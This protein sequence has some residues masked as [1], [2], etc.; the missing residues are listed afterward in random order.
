MQA[1]GSVGVGQTK[2]PQYGAF[3]S[4]WVTGSVTVNP[5]VGANVWFYANN[6]SNFRAA[7]WWPDR[8]SGGVG[9]TE[10]HSDVDFYAYNPSGAEAGRSTTGPQVWE[11]VFLNGSQTNGWWRFLV[12]PATVQ[13]NQTVYYTI[14]SYTC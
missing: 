12:Q 8:I 2:F 7:I 10:L 3:C 9:G 14:Y 4:H 13:S 1:Y 11:S 5:G 6:E